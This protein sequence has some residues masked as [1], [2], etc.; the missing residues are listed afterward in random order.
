MR[1]EGVAKDD[2]ASMAELIETYRGTVYP[3]HCD[4]MQHMNVMW[5]AGKFD[6]G[7]W[8][9]FAHVGITHAYM[10]AN[11][12]GMAAVDQRIA[13]QNELHAGDTVVVRSGVIE[14][15]EKL[16][17]FVHEM[18]NTDTG[19]TCAVTLLT[20]LHM[21]MQTRKSCPLPPAIVECAR[22]HIVDYTLPW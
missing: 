4:H 8:H 3:W 22:R 18:R 16:V 20:A 15:R 17:R 12:R 1:L 14:V 5:Y 13:Y 9:F 2:G 6:E 7:T 19:V 21:D 11:S 10:Q